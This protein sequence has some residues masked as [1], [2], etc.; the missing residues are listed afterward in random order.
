MRVLRTLRDSRAI[1]E[2]AVSR[3]AV[4]VG[5]SFIGLEVAA[6]LRAREL[7][8]HVVAPDA[9]DGRILGP[10]LGDFIRSLHEEHGGV[11]PAADQT[12]PSTTGASD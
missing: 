8:V 5:A 3:R 1:I 11:P 10:E 9:A 7:E 6:S 2:Q 12:V 4:V